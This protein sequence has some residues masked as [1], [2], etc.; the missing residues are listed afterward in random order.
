MKT[1]LT[2]PAFDAW[3]EGLRDKMTARRIQARLDRGEDG[4]FGDCRAIAEGVMELRIHHGP[5]YRIYFTQ[6][7]ENIVVLLAGGSKSP[8]QQD[9][10]TALAT[11]REL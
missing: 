1:L 2:T 8:Q 11:A 7:R 5:G 3:F 10:D 9:I 6:R 4:N